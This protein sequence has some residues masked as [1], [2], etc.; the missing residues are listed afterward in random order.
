[1]FPPQRIRY[2]LSLTNLSNNW[3]IRASLADGYGGSCS[4]QT[5]NC[6]G[7]FEDKRRA[8]VY[9]KRREFNV[10]VLELEING[11]I[12]TLPGGRITRA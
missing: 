11:F 6:L 10:Q 4:F 12:K 2:D 1:M 3:S 9:V 5:K 8:V 7:S